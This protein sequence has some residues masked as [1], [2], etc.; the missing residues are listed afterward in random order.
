MLYLYGK[1]TVIYHH[2]DRANIG[3]LWDLL[4]DKFNMGYIVWNAPR[5]QK[6]R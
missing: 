2:L 3:W 5:K 6:I 4:F 1:F